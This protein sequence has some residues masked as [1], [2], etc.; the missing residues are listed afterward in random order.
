M[1]LYFVTFAIN[2]NCNLK[3]LG[4]TPDRSTRIF[5][6]ACLCHLLN[7]TSISS[8]V[9]FP[10]ISLYGV[11]PNEKTDLVGHCACNSGMVQK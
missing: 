7:N 2:S 1:L 6:R 8:N 3:V 4:S 11:W 10:V 5:F 9:L